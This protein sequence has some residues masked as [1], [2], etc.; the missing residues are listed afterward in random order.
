MGSSCAAGGAAA[1]GGNSGCTPRVGQGFSA[2]LTAY[3][4]HPT[5]SSKSVDEIHAATL[6][7]SAALSDADLVKSKQSIAMYRDFGVDL[8]LPQDELQKRLPKNW[9]KETPQPLSGEYLAPYSV[10]AAFYHPIPCDTPSTQ[11][12]SGYFDGVQVNSLHGFDNLGYGLAIGKSSDPLSAL[13]ADCCG[14]GMNQTL[15]IPS[16]AL[17]QLGQNGDWALVESPESRHSTAFCPMARSSS[18]IPRWISANWS[19]RCR[20]GGSLKPYKP[21]GRMS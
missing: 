19:S 11:L 10:D 17:S 3:A 9:S 18:S 16:D 14:D 13:T 21:T 2:G 4:K 15:H 1:T 5:A 12:P 20:H 6:A 8:S 7:A